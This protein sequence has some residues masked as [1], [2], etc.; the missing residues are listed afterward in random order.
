L[1]GKVIQGQYELKNQE[2]LLAVLGSESFSNLN[3]KGGAIQDK[4]LKIV[5]K[6]IECEE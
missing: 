1:F 6:K 2:N 4:D 3:G 5:V